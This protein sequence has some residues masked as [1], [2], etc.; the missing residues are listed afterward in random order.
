[1]LHIRSVR[2]AALVALLSPSLIS[3]RVVQDE[4]RSAAPNYDAF[5]NWMSQSLKRNEAGMSDEL[6]KRQ[7]P[8]ANCVQDDTLIELSSNPYFAPYCS[9]YIGIGPTT[10]TLVETP[11]V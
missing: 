9:S 3:G 7:Q 8:N 2:V 1:M 6:A 5:P 4:K 11:V 10:T